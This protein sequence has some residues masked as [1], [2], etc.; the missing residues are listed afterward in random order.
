MPSKSEPGSFS[1]HSVKGRQ[2]VCH[3][4]SLG[5]VDIM[6]EGEREDVHTLHLYMFV[7]LWHATILLD[8]DT[9]VAI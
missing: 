5:Q 3:M 4:Y 9:G 7:S 8:M 1:H 2:A 6:K